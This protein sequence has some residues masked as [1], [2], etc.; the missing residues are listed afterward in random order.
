MM[1]PGLS[2]DELEVMGY[3]RQYD[4]TQYSHDNH[5]N[6]I[7]EQSFKRLVHDTFQTI[8]DVL[9]ET[10]GPYGSTVVISD[11]NETTTTKDGYNVFEAMGF[12]HHYKRMVYLAIKKI[13]ERVNRNVGD[14]TT[15]CILLADKM[16]TKINDLIKTADDKRNILSVLSSIEKHL[17][18][19]SIIDS[20]IANGIC[21]PLTKESLMN[22]I[23]LA[24]NYDPSLTTTLFNAM[25]P[26]TNEDGVVTR[27]RNVIAEAEVARNGDSTADYKIHYMPGDYRVRAN[28]DVEVGR[29]MQNPV[30]V[31]LAIYDHAFGANDWANFMAKYDRQTRVIILAPSFTKSFIENEYARY[32]RDLKLAQKALP[33]IAVAEIKGDFVQNEIKDL[34]AVLD[35]HVY[36]LHNTEPVDHDS[37]VTATVQVFHGNALCFHNVKP[38]TQYIDKVEA[39]MKKD[40]T[41]SYI[42]KND[43]IVRLKALSLDSKDTIVQVRAGTSLEVKMLSD[44]IDDCVSIVGSAIN[45][46]IVPNMLRYAYKRM[47]IIS[48]GDSFDSELHY[49]V[50]TAIAASIEGLFSDVWKSKYGDSQ[51]ETMADR[52]DSFY[53]DWMSYDIINDEFVDIDKLPTSTQYDL[54]VVVAAISIV[55]YL[56]TSRAL[57]FDAHLMTA[58]GDQGHYRQM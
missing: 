34:A 33:D 2:H 23:L 46:G 11:Q 28:I 24:S 36:G 38:P 43:Y 10:Y 17:Q 5:V 31:K 55:K 56:L 44:K 26:T 18:D 12:S 40:M 16:F 42:K 15:S 30:D 7:P 27:I 39:E 47:A 29:S 37:L 13:C 49:S 54:E 20:D 57:I 1:Q 21:K 58:H 9:K 4:Y 6:V 22:I 52:L 41:K 3:T 50:A 19:L 14:G 35:T 48:K 8:C 51:A 32:G 25:D 45:N 53:T